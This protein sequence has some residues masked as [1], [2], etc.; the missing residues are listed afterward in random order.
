MVEGPEESPAHS[1]GPPSPERVQATLALPDQ[2]LGVVSSVQ[3]LLA[4]TPLCSRAFPPPPIPAS[5]E[6]K[7]PPPPVF[8]ACEN[9]G[10]K[11]QKLRL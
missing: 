5:P 4:L 11:T 7:R 3:V 10:S 1:E 9:D 2:G 8:V 6:S